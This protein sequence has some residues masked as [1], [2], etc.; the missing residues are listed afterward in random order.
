MIS[1]GHIR[2]SLAWLAGSS[3]KDPY[4]TN[5][6]R[7]LENP[8]IVAATAV[9]HHSQEWYHAASDLTSLVCS[10]GETYNLSLTVKL[11]TTPQ[12]F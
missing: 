8:L 10:S 9:R 2:V 6:K 11:I 1:D 5:T 3:A 7:R 4:R 12:I